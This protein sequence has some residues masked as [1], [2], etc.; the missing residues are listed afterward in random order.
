MEAF[1]PEAFP[2][3]GEGAEPNTPLILAVNDV[4]YNT[5]TTGTGE[6]SVDI[7][8]TE[9]DY[10]DLTLIAYCSGHTSAAVTGTWAE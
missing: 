4:E 7:D 8:L 5:M 1:N 9:F 10:G 3:Y 6:F 2:V